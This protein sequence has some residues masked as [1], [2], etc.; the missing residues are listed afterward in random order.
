MR[1]RGQVVEVLV[2]LALVIILVVFV[3]GFLYVNLPLA[4]RPVLGPLVV[5]AFCLVPAAIAIAVAALTASGP[6]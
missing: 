6:T 3:L 1:P 5:G 2:G 4:R